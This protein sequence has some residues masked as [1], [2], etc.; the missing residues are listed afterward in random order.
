MQTSLVV[1]A[2]LFGPRSS[3]AF[4]RITDSANE[5]GHGSRASLLE[6]DNITAVS[7]KAS[8]FAY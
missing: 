5:L 3:E 2:A 4:L 8:G 1:L 6:A 7:G